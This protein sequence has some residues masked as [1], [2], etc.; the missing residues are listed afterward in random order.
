MGNVVKLLL[1]IFLI[2]SRFGQSAA[3]KNTFDG[4]K[5]QSEKE[6]KIEGKK[7]VLDNLTK[8]DEKGNKAEE[9]DYNS[10]GDQKSR[11]VYEYNNNGKCIKE[12][13]YDN[14]NKLS[15]TVTFEYHENGKRKTQYNYLPN[16]KLRNTKEFE[17]I[18]E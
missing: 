10:V 11:V 4:K 15:K 9:I 2:I 16:G 3:Q 5:N 1:C 18:L 6:W 12:T 17:Y 13:H 8:Y 7:K 14:Y